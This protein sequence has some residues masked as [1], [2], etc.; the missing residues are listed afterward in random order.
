MPD[1]TEIIKRAKPR[2]KTVP[3]YLAGDEAAEVERLEAELAGL[4]G[5]WQPDSLGAKH[6]G[7][8]LAKQI[9]AARERLKKSKVDFRLRSLGRLAYSD[10]VAAHPSKDKNQLWD[11][12]TFPQA[13]LAEC[14]I[15]PVMSAEQV[16]E[17][18][19]V[20]NEGQRTE[21][22]QAAY[23]V[24]AEATSV[25]FSV[26]ASSILASLTDGK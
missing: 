12:A 19:E 17:L 2:E 13:L 18:F 20:L 8:K 14:C 11:P 22:C 10:L 23:D 25:P 5:T 9:A 4:S 21:L 24:N 16:A 7:E 15:E 6:P 3:L 26:S 1:I